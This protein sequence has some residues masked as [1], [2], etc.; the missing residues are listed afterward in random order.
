MVVFLFN[1]FLWSAVSYSYGRGM[2][3][4]YSFKQQTQKQ[5]FS[6]IVKKSLTCEWVVE[7]K[8]YY[9]LFIIFVSGLCSL[10]Y[11]FI[12]QFF[13]RIRNSFFNLSKNAEFIK[14]TSI[15]MDN[16]RTIQHHVNWNRVSWFVMN[17][18]SHW[19][20]YQLHSY[21]IAWFQR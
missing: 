1:N 18:F 8:Y 14:A 7:P 10:C 16:V 20:K 11:T 21:Y 2:L 13:R 15:C 5:C 6:I 3:T 9:N 17:L 4:S 19:L 12:M